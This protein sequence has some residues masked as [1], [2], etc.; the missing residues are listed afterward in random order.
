M[1]DVVEEIV[2]ASDLFKQLLYF[3]A[4]VLSLIPNFLQ[5]LPVWLVG[6]CT[7]YI[8]LSIA[9]LVVGRG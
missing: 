3:L 6:V 7:A 8:V 1:G 4:D 5:S 9:F 2:K